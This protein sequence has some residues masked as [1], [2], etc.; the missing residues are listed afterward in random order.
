M[1]GKLFESDD[2]ISDVVRRCRGFREFVKSEI[3][4]GVVSEA[5]VVPLVLMKIMNLYNTLVQR[6]Y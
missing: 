1:Y 5:I 6:K 2:Y 3:L 4:K